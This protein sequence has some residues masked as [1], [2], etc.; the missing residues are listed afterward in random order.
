MNSTKFKLDKQQGNQ[1]SV[2]FNNKS[3]SNNK[4]FEPYLRVWLQRIK[5]LGPQKC[6]FTNLKQ[7]L[8][9]QRES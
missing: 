2:Q 3:V 5:N 8:E 1:N 9:K 4:I 7:M 6:V